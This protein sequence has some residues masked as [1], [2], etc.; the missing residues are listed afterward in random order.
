MTHP[1]FRDREEEPGKKPSAA[2]FHMVRCLAQY[3][4][5]DVNVH[6]PLY[7]AGL[8]FEGWERYHDLQRA[9]TDS[10]IAFMAM[11]FGNDVLDRMYRDCFKPAVDATGFDLRRIDEAPRPA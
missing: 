10:R 4:R 11:P 6:T 2:E 9:T 5:L 3:L 7:D 8:T 1:V